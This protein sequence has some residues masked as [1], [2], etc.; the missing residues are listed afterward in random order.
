MQQM[1]CRE[2]S[3]LEGQKQFQPPWSTVWP[4]S[5]TVISRCNPY[6]LCPGSPNKA[7]LQP[8]PFPSSVLWAHQPQI[9]PMLGSASLHRAATG[10]IRGPAIP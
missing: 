6:L 7:L 5:L 1:G 2:V 3:Y 10:D 4:Q 8:A 9:P